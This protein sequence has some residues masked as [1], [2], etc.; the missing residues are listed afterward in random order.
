MSV[1]NTSVSES[2]SSLSESV[3][4]ETECVRDGMHSLVGKFMTTD[5]LLDH[6][7]PDNSSDLFG[8]IPKGI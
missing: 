7:S 8:G 1:S 4:S 5:Q 2:E 3:A 6:I